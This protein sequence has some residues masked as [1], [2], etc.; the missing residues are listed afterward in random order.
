MSVKNRLR[1]ITLIYDL[2]RQLIMKYKRLRYGLKHVHPTFYMSGNSYISKDFIA[3]EYSFINYECHICPKVE[4]GAYVMFG[5]KV[6]IVGAD[7]RYDIPGTPM[8]FSGRP[9]LKK[10]II[11]SDVW[12]GYGAIIMAGV[13]ISRGSIVAAGSIVTKDI[14]PYEIHGG[15]PAKKI[16]DR[17]ST[18]ADREIHDKLLC[19]PPV[20]GSF[21]QPLA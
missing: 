18:T 19:S 5:P 21:T 1:K 6:T 7:H 2:A 12:I 13:T 4:I 10:T 15:I 16:A 20:K 8:I 3:R 14:P 11:E 9:P 17:F